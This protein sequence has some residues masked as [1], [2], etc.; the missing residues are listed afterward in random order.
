VHPLFWVWNQMKRRCNDPKHG[1]YKNYGGKGIKVCDEWASDFKTFFDWAIKKG[2][3]KGLTVERK[4]NELGYNEDN[5]IIA[6][7]LV[8]SRNKRSNILV[9]A[10]GETKCLMDWFND[11]RCLVGTYQCLKDRI[12]KWNWEPERAISTHA[13]NNGNRVKR[14]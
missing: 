2:W 9:S 5:C 14:K 4:N 6:S 11:S 1:S 7:Y 10:F 12:L 3:K 13:L 8:Q